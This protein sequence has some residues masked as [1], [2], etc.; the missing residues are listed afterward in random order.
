MATLS[1]PAQVDLT[2]YQG[3]ELSVQYEWTHDGVVQSL[4]GYTAQSQIRDYVG[5]VLILDLAPYLSIDTTANR[6]I[7]NVP[8]GITHA[9]TNDGCWDMFL[10]AADPDATVMLLE[11][12]VI[13]KRAV[14]QV[15]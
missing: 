14:T 7:L 10:V 11:G 6:V 13:L 1:S 8:A 2:I 15:V 9:V 12:K 3:S 4:A 5:G